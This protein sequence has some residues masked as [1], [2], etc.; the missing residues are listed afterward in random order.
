M[1]TP[2][3]APLKDINAALESYQRYILALL[4]S[5]RRNH[6]LLN[7]KLEISLF[8]FPGPYMNIVA[9]SGPLIAM[10]FPSVADLGHL[11]RD[12][13]DTVDRFYCDSLR[14]CRPRRC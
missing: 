11:G 4:D 2:G 1:P 13:G 9:M 5:Y 6:S 12:Y 3:C 8:K 10:A 14:F 7:G